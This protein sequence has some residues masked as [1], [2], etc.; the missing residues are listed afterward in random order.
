MMGGRTRCL[1]TLLLLPALA[2]GCSVSRSMRVRSGEDPVYRDDDVRFRTTYYFR[3]F[4]ACE[5]VNEAE[6][7]SP[8]EDTVFRGKEKGPY[9]L[10]ADS[11]YRFRM[12]GK[13]YSFF[14][15]I[16]FESGT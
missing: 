16:H 10:R 14:Q 2:T 12:T 9:Q 5:G 4:D 3:V 7:K 13:G 1:A 11:L 8:R 6:N 15:R